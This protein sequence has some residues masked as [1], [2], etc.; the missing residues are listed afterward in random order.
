MVLDP[1][2]DLAKLICGI[3]DVQPSGRDDG[4]TAK[5]FGTMAAPALLPLG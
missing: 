2:G 4:R 3:D 5:T 1:M